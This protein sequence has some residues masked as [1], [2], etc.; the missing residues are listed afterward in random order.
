MGGRAPPPEPCQAGP[1]A[2]AR[3]KSLHADV[4]G[5]GRANRWRSAS[6]MSA[7]RVPATSA[8]P[9]R[10]WCS[11][12]RPEGALLWL[13]IVGTAARFAVAWALGL[14]NGE[15][16]Y[17]TAA[18]HLSLSS[19]DQPPLAL[20]IAHLSLRLTGSVDPPPV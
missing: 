11:L 16:Y 20:W 5:T 7:D 19:L 2:L 4:G 6:A 8:E 3:A 10:E 17:F 18:R 12:R 1:G 14:G 15:S 9:Q 13:I